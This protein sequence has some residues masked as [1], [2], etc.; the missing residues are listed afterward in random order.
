MPAN[1][2]CSLMVMSA[3]RF[4]LITTRVSVSDKYKKSGEKVAVTAVL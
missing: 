3:S 1:D 2:L 4:F